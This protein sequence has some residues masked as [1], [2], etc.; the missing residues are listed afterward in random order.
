MTKKILIVDDSKAMR[1]LIRRSLRE[2]GYGEHTFFEASNGLEALDLIK[3]NGPDLVLLDWNMPGM[4]GIE[5]LAKLK[6]DGLRARCGMITTETSPEMANRAFEAGALFVIK[7][8]F[9]TE[10]LETTLRRALG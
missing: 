9:T 4:T 7:K 1:L 10:I 8:P 5:L 6:Q 2:A 3:A